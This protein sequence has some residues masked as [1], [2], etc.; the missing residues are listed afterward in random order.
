MGFVFIIFVI[1]VIYYWGK[2]KEQEELKDQVIYNVQEEQTRV[3]IVPEGV[4]RIIGTLDFIS[5]NNITEKIV[6]P[7]GVTCI[8]GGACSGFMKL[9]DIKLPQSLRKIEPYAFAKC[10]VLENIEIPMG[11]TDIEMLA[12]NDCISLKS[13]SLPDTVVNIPIGAFTGCESLRKII[14]SDSMV[15]KIKEGE[16]TTQNFR[17]FL[18]IPNIAELIVRTSRGTDI[19]KNLIRNGWKVEYR[20]EINN[21]ANNGTI[22]AES[23]AIPDENENNKDNISDDENQLEGKIN[24]F[25]LN[26]YAVA[27]SDEKIVNAGF[28]HDFSK[29]ILG[30]GFWNS[31]DVLRHFLGGNN[32]FN[33][34]AY[35]I[36]NYTKGG[37]QKTL[38]VAKEACSYA[39][40]KGNRLEALRFL[41]YANNIIDNKA[42]IANI[43]GMLIKYCKAKQIDI[44]EW[45]NAFSYDVGVHSIAMLYKTNRKMYMDVAYEC[46]II[47]QEASKLYSNSKMA[48]SAIFLRGLCYA[49]TE[50]EAGFYQ[51]LET[52]PPNMWSEI[53]IDIENIKKT[54]KECGFYSKY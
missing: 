5:N 52:S 47:L 19:E 48:T 37:T 13:I 18:D 28:K 6:I 45:F 1:I 3:V 38:N 32:V 30:G 7:E 23:K 49:N 27:F 2:S 50:K 42:H 16:Q 12:F 10:S 22:Y 29:F 15:N 34:Y 25:I 8:D 35:K 46:C 9:K 11:V 36:L 53:E 31:A 43:G 54:W 21:K 20:E 14:I 4:R 41:L 44:P 51:K 24:K 33:T 17:K 40:K 26:E 39:I